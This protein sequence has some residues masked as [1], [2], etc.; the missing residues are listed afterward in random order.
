MKNRVETA[1]SLA[2]IEP[3]SL[4]SMRNRSDS[5]EDDVYESKDGHR[6]GN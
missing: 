6:R 1:W 4:E 5:E 2:E 3:C